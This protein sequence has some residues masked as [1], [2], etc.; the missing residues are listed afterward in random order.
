MVDDHVC[1]L[2]ILTNG[3]FGGIGSNNSHNSCLL[4]CEN[5][6]IPYLFGT[7]LRCGLLKF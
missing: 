4:Q 5:V 1:S 3:E 6:S 7:I 2:Q